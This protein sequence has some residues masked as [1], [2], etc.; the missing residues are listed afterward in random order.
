M[1]SKLVKIAALLCALTM[2]LGVFAG[3][4]NQNSSKAPES[5]AANTPE[6]STAPVSSETAGTSDG[7]NTSEEVE[8]T[9]YLIGDRP[10]KQDEVEENY[11]RLFKEK[12]NCTVKTNYLSWAEYRNKYPLIFS[13]GEEFD[14]AYA[15]SWLNYYQLAQK[16]AFKSL[17][18]LWP[19]YAPN[20]FAKQSESAKEQATVNDHYYGIPTLYK[21]YSA[22]GP[23][24][25]TDILEGTDWD[26][27][28]E[29]LNDY[30]VYLSYVKEAAPEM[31]PIAIVS[32]GSEI[33]EL[34]MQG[35]GLYAVKGGNGDFLW[36]DPSEAEPK[37][38][39]Y[40]DYEGTTEFL[41]LVN[42]WNENGYFT[43]SAL[44]DTDTAKVESGKAASRIKNM[45]TYEGE[46][47]KHPEWGFKFANFVSDVSYSSF[48]QD[49]LVISNTSKN[50]ERALAWYDLI[51][52][53]EE[54]FRA[55]DYGIEGTSYEVIDNQVKM[56]NIDDY[57]ESS[58][59]AART[60]EF[61]LPVYGSPSDIKEMEKEFDTQIQDGVGCQKFRG[62]NIDTSNVETEYAACI[63]VH[64]Q[65]WWPLE[66]GYTDPV[67]GLEEYKQKMQAA[68]IDKVIEEFQSQLDEYLKQ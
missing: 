15:A 29:N 68:G 41:E 40:Y 24:Y 32:E 49:G 67:T 62:F 42:R 51:T 61:F 26:G 55:W 10:A 12:L 43:K 4:G 59:W 57:S 48:M 66:L 18:E 3:C 6:S 33:D 16:G 25:R 20:N 54:A 56:L 45:G 39:T 37:I 65:Y 31:E 14:M 23:V 35:R 17:D 53:D 63:N 22:Y 44:S 2:I 38:F 5:S 9:L 8:L 30:E 1:K 46:H 13:S 58:L 52:T 50:P 36:L 11:N 7:L 47:M 21:T 64:Q 28:M 19:T 60:P 34:F 27:K